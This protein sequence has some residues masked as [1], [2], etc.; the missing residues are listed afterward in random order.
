LKIETQP[1]EEHQVKII[2][3]FDPE[4]LEKYKQRAARKIS[5]SARIPGFRPGKAPYAVIRRMYGDD[6]I[7]HEAIDLLLD[8]E[9]QEVIKEAGIHPAAPGT[10][11]EI[12][13]TN[14][15]KLAFSVPLAPE[16]KLGDY[17]SIRKPYEIAVITEDRVDQVVKNMRANYSTAESVNR[18]AQEGDL[19]SVK[20]SG[21]FTNPSEG[22]DVIAIAEST[23]QMIVGENEFEVDDWPYE[24]FTRELVGMS[25]DEE[26][27]ISHT[28]SLEDPD[29]KLR[30]KEVKI[31]LKVLGIKLLT[32]PAV[33]DEFAQ[34]LGEFQTVEALRKSIRQTLEENEKREYDNKYLTSLV[35]EIR[36]M[37]T[38]LYPP[39][40]LQ[41]EVER[42]IKSLEEDLAQQKMD[43][44][45]YLKTINKDKEAFVESEA[46][47]VARQRLE[48]SLVLDEMA[49]AENIQLD[50]E[51]LQKESTKT[52]ASLQKDPE[53]RKMAKGRQAEDLVRGVTME[54]ANRVLNRQVLERLKTIAK[55]EFESKAETVPAEL[56]SDPESAESL[57][58]AASAEITNQPVVA[59]TP[60]AEESSEVI[61]E[62]KVKKARKK[63]V[64]TNA[65]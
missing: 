60:S 57:S 3:E 32:L 42:V 27:E 5:E 43:L 4:V 30:G 38:I 52:I 7:Q 9:Y 40:I 16:V 6:A 23:P 12:I 61:T 49:H 39:Q 25:V 15:P 8:N 64:E 20:I 59:E 24:S 18:P 62:P 47:P 53:F 48:R 34:S 26:K 63:K 11:E 65:E 35:D 13:S 10:L 41:E 14:P 50:M 54:S 55:G 51:E 56:T 1:L 17:H 46:K 22:E 58:I 37:S 44:S 28:F 29:E 45:T 19:V 21:V 33:T 2:A 36:G 31:R